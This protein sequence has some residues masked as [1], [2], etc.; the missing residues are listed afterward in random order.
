MR[1]REEYW[2]AVGAVLD[3]EVPVLSVIDLGIVRDMREE[4]GTV[5]VD[6][7][8]TY[9]GC[10]AMQTIEHDIVEALEKAGAPRV[11]VNT[12]F[13]PAWTTDWISADAKERLR[14]YGIAPPSGTAAVATELIPLQRRQDIITCPHCGSRNTERRS[15]F[16]STAC[17]AIYYCAGCAEPFEYFKP[18]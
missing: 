11:V 15:E 16:G 14:A 3:P 18:L 13:Q 8:P 4:R 6:V 1:A 17:K 5:V 10:P 7:T 2:A 9:S 12:I